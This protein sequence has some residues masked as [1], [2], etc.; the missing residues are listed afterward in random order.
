MALDPLLAT[1]GNRRVLI[2]ERFLPHLS[3]LLLKKQ[4]MVVSGAIAVI[5]TLSLSGIEPICPR[6]EPIAD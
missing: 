4:E 6:L 3:S 5:N 2:E 1:D